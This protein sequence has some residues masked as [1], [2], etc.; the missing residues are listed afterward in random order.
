MTSRITGND[1]Q[2]QAPRHWSC[3]GGIHQNTSTK[4]ALLCSHWY[5]YTSIYMMTPSDGNIFRVTGL[6]WGKCTSHRWTPS[7][8]PVTQNFEFLLD[9]RLNK[10]LSKRSRHWWFETAPRSL[11]RHCNVVSRV[12]IWED[13]E[14]R[15]ILFDFMLTMTCMDL[16][17]GCDVLYR[18]L[19]VPYDITVWPYRSRITP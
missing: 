3:V 9:L 6:L 16:F 19:S 7:Q 13:Y 11:W 8:R 10:W 18:L 4:F 2:F 14:P 17:G 5:H 12:P 1:R 15:R